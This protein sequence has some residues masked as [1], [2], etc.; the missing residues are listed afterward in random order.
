MTDRDDAG[1]AMPH[2]SDVSAAQLGW[3]SE[4]DSG[5]HIL[6]LGCGDG[7]VAAAI[8]SE[9]SR[10]VAVD[11]DPI[12]IDRC[13]NSSPD[14]ELVEADMCSLKSDIGRFDM[15]LCLGNTFCLLW[16]VDVAVAALK[17]W[18]EL[19]IEGGM[20]VLDDLPGD[21]WPEVATGNWLSGFSEDG[22][23]QLVWAED[24]AVLA[25]REGEAVDVDS[26]ALRED[27]QRMRIWTMGAMRLAAAAAGLTAT[28]I[29]EGGVLVMR[30]A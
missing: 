22:D 6:D 14:V 27:D 19:L 12:A 10:Y 5:M 20:I 23:C 7:R 15:V 30:P 3:L 18:H 28:R 26:W 8:G 11:C 13:R 17:S 2:D 29:P 16:D 4:C 24:D 9:A 1:A 21:H 25:I